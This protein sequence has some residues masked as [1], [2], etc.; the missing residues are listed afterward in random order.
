MKIIVQ[1]G[2]LTEKAVDAIVNA[3]NHSL[4]GGGG[5]DGAIHRKA[6]PKLR[7][8]NKGLGG[9]ETGKAKLSPGF[10]LPAKYV[11]STVGPIW[12]QPYEEKEKLL[13]SCYTNS[14]Q[15]AK[16]QGLRTVAFPSISTG[17]YGYPVEKAAKVAMKAILDFGQAH[18]DALSCV[19]MVN[20]SETDRAVYQQALDEL[21]E[22]ECR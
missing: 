19:Y 14:L 12:G 21:L 4:L 20:F 7:E 11:I 2:D 3:A 8:Y 1:K 22:G 5:V 16:E 9:C 6:G 15:L 13:R 17:V 10:Q 18:P